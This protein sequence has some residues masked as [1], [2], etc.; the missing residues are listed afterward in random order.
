MTAEIAILN[1]TAVA[2]ATDSAVT[3]GRGENAK[4]YLSENKLFELS[5]IKPVGL[6]L[7][8]A[9]DF[10]GVPWEIMIKDFRQERGRDAQPKV[11]NWKDA[12]LDSATS[13]NIP[14]D[15]RQTQQLLLRLRECI[16]HIGN[17]LIARFRE[18]RRT[19]P[20]KKGKPLT[21]KQRFDAIHAQLV[22]D[23]VEKLEQYE[24]CAS[25]GDGLF[26]KP[27][28]E[29]HDAE[30]RKLEDRFIPF[31]LSD[32]QRSSL[33]EIYWHFLYRK[34]PSDLCTGFVFAGFGD[35]E[36]FPALHHVMVD[37]VF[38]GHLKVFEVDDAYCVDSSQAIGT[39]KA[40]AQPDM[41]HRFLYGIDDVLEENIADY[42]LATIRKLEKTIAAEFKFGAKRAA[43]LKNTLLKYAQ[44]VEREYFDSASDQLKAEYFA[45]IEDMVRLMPKQEM[46][47]LAEAL[48]N[49]TIIKR[50]ASAERETVGGPIDVAVIS[51]H[52]GFVWVKRKHYFD[53]E[54][55]PR[56]FWRRFQRSGKDGQ[57]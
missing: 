40:F 18:S 4:T 28:I 20:R 51:R 56:Y 41:A 30:L 21:F 6:M 22:K 45:T 46:A 38:D 37:G 8:N 19:P 33:R 54:L 53:A 39:V 44:E 14:D 9:L 26:I 57:T 35:D 52:E 10:Y 24:A 43:E 29:K 15:A 11:V 36:P 55:N 48:V 32:S 5:D 7:Y 2:L 3:I 49:I 12:F 47:Q 23:K 1:R 17:D 25:L 16:E 13:K 31:P 27:Y 42:F 50:K 34:I